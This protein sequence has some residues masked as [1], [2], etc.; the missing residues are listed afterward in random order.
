MSPRL[1]Q[2]SKV[3][4]SELPPEVSAE[5]IYVQ[6]KQLN[7]KIAFLKDRQVQLQAETRRV[8]E[9]GSMRAAF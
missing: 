2:V 3:S 1:R 9:A 4:S 8:T 5:P 7:E 6:M